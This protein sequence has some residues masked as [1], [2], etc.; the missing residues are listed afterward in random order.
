MHLDFCGGVDDA[1]ARPWETEAANLGDSRGGE[2]RVRPAR[3]T[4]EETANIYAA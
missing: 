2:R 1:T 3:D 4:D